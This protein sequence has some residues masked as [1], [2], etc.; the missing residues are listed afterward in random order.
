MQL[1]PL[2]QRFIA[3]KSER[4]VSARQLHEFLGIGR[5]FSNW[6]TGQIDRFEFRDNQDFIRVFAKN[7]EKS[8][9][10]RPTAEYWLTL[11][12][13]KELAMLARTAK[14][15][16]ARRYF[17]DCERQLQEQ[18]FAKVQA[19]QQPE[20]LPA[21]EGPAQPSKAVRSAINRKAHAVS[22]Q[23]YESA[24]AE[25]E[26]V[27]QEWLGKGPADDVG[28]V[29]RVG[30]LTYPKGEQQIVSAEDLW[31]V[32]SFTAAMRVSFDGLMDAIHHLEQETGRE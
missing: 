20:S 28:L 7:G 24:K 22:M 9:R 23:A 2:P 31:A 21:P 18:Q 10:G 6:I 1:I 32:T 15:R 30:R 14:G 17:I 8:G 25:I 16:E 27:V 13:A 12:M 5:D 11:D 29:Y 4:T 26:A 3:G 19:A